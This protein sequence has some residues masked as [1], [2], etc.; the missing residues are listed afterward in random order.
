MYIKY[1]RHCLRRATMIFVSTTFA[2]LGICRSFFFSFFFFHSDL[3]CIF[4][5]AYY[6]IHFSN[7]LA[8]ISD[9]ICIRLGKTAPIVVERSG[10]RGVKKKSLNL[11]L[12]TVLSTVG[13]VCKKSRKAAAAI[14][15]TRH[16]LNVKHPKVFRAHRSLVLSRR[17][18]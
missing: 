3:R 6:S 14:V 8:S 17:S 13:L 10:K 7:D 18:M 16:F 11:A 1:D 2:A 5:G 15:F 9:S 4:R 12:Q